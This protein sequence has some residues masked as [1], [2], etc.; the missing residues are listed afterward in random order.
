[1]AA[2]AARRSAGDSHAHSDTSSGFGR[3]LSH[4]VVTGAGLHQDGGLDQSVKDAQCTG[5][6]DQCK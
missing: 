1:M 2:T 4:L 5:R 3:D 6:E